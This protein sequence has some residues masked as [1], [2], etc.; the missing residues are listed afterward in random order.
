[1]L[2]GL[3]A[4]ARRIVQRHRAEQELDEE[5]AFHVEME[6][7]RNIELGMEPA[8]ARRRAL[9]DLGGDTQVR[10]AVVDERRT[11]LDATWQDVLHASRGLLRSRGVALAVL[12]TLTLA[13]TASLALFTIVDGV[14]LRPL[15]LP[16]SERVVRVSQIP[17]A[18]W[19]K[20]MGDHPAPV[21]ASD[22]AALSER[23]RSFEVLVAASLN[24]SQVLQG[25]GRPVPVMGTAVTSG[26]FEFVGARP[27]L[28]RMF[29]KD[30]YQLGAGPRGERVEPRGG[31]VILSHQFWQR[32]FGGAT[33]IIGRVIQL[34]D[35]EFRV[36]G[37]MPPNEAYKE[38]LPLGADCL[39]PVYYR[40][41]TGRSA[42]FMFTY[43]RLRGGTTLAQAQADVE[44]IGNSLVQKRDRSR[45]GR[46]EL[47]QEVLGRRVRTELL[48]LGWAALL[49]LVI[50]CVNAGNLLLAKTTARW[51]ELATRLALG[52]S[53][54]QLARL[55]CT[56]A[57][58]LSLVATAAA[59]PLASLCI[60]AVVNLPAEHLPRVTSLH[61]DARVWLFALAV[62]VLTAAL[63]SVG[64]LLRLRD[65]RVSGPLRQGHVVTGNRR[66]A[67][68]SQGLIALEV[69]LTCVLLLATGLV[70]RTVVNLRAAN[71]GYDP[72]GIFVVNLSAESKKYNE[73]PVW[74]ALVAAALE[75]I[76]RVPGVQ[77]ADEGS[78]PLRIGFGSGL[79]IDDQQEPVMWALDP[80]GPEFF[81]A[82]RLPIVRGRGFSQSD[83]STATRVA[84]L[85]ERAYAAA[86]H[87]R[88]ID[89][90]TIRMGKTVIQVIGV[91]RDA[92]RTGLEAQL[93]PV[94][95]VLASQEEHFQGGTIVVRATDPAHVI[96]PVTAALRTLDPAEP[97]ATAVTFDE[98]FDAA[99]ARRDRDLYVLGT[100][101]AVALALALGGVAAVVYFAA[102]E[103]RREIAIRAVLG[104][105]ASKAAGAVAS[106]TLWAVVMGLLIGVGVTL[107]FHRLFSDM[108]FG[109]ATTDPTTYAVV[110]TGCLAVTA[111]ACLW[112]AWRATRGDLI[113]PLR[114][115]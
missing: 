77:A 100:F 19:A 33:S 78:S 9:I 85:S 52:A 57:L 36:V 3:L 46:L 68:V 29:E 5:L 31:A 107:A 94:V 96:P 110:S 90:C 88:P 30:E 59:L 103:R 16:H 25:A 79:T 1:M 55:L 47:V 91:A 112:P 99:M 65:I 58:L 45:L 108:V 83:A 69:T 54:W 2:R 92:R 13:L 17:D 73:R 22:F 34:G 39:F 11:V 56:E 74:R 21:S 102:T 49:L 87:D 109:V 115:E 70:V 20:T 38:I 106:G 61:V 98:E 60:R 41:G 26:F 62:A 84:V 113:T 114:C 101:S 53:R 23:N 82:V 86:C 111:L 64:P 89:A 15:D 51:R 105:S 12:A 42:S 6:T 93:E 37:I 24:R 50:G 35:Q 7:A 32:Q 40:E 80:I 95:Y 48:L 76:R 10:E 18:R 43:G 28:G 75:R 71:L 67:R 14:L 27:I 66:A 4:T 72:S 44:H 104:A 63:S 97:D 8:D 81:R